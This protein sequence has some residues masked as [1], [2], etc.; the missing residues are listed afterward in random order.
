MLCSMNIIGWLIM[1][2]F[3]M[4]T[5]QYRE[6]R[7]L[8]LKANRRIKSTHKEYKKHGLS[9]LPREVVG[10]IQHT[11]QWAT[12]RSPLS[13][14]KKQFTSQKEFKQHMDYLKTFDGGRPTVGEY[15]KQQRRQTISSMQSALDG[16]DGDYVLPKNIEDKINKMSAPQLA[17]FWKEF[18]ERGDRLAMDYASDQ[19]LLQ[20]MQDLF[21]EDLD[22]IVPK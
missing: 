18:E 2:K 7:R 5:K 4:T 22:S 15:S 6:L 12:T 9:V 19:A 11:S 13:S 17:K 16:F 8:T 21:P 20:T 3:N 14:S 10:K 1:S